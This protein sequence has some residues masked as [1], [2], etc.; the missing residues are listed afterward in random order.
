[1][2]SDIFAFLYFFDLTVF[3]RRTDLFITQDLISILCSYVWLE[4]KD[5]VGNKTG[6]YSLRRSGMLKR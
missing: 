4:R 6:F 1:M 2:Q 3:A 5:K